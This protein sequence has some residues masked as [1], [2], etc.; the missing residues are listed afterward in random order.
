MMKASINNLCSVN[1]NGT[2]Y[3]VEWW[4]K[5]PKGKKKL[6]PKTMCEYCMYSEKNQAKLKEQIGKKP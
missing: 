4:F 6:N 2:W 3:H 1:K 5:L